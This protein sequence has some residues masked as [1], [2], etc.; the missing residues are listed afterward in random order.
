M[1][2]AKRIGAANFNLL[3]IDTENK[4]RAYSLSMACRC[5][6]C[7]ALHT[8]RCCAGDGVGRSRNVG[9]GCCACEQFVSTGFAEEI[10][11]GASGRYYYLPNVRTSVHDRGV[12]LHTLVR[13]H[14]AA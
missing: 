8:C 7:T 12:I 2:M 4:V 5:S 13:L 3:V 14:A 6:A 11:R 10:A 1:S 9:D